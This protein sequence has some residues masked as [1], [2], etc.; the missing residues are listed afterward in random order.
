M[1]KYSNII[2]MITAGLLITGCGGSSNSSSVIINTDQPGFLLSKVVNSPEFNP[3]GNIT[4]TN[5]IFSWPATKNATQYQ[6]GHEDPNDINSWVSHDILASEANCNATGSRYCKFQ[7][8]NNNFP[9]GSFRA[10][11]VRAKVNGI[12]KNWSSSHTFT[13]VKD[14]VSV[15][16]P[17]TIAPTGSVN[18]TNPK[19][20]WTGVVNA[21]EYRLGYEEQTTENSWVEHTLSATDLGCQNLAQK[22]VFTPAINTFKN[23]DH[24]GWYVR[25]YSAGN[26]GEW[27][28]VKTFDVGIT[29][30]TA[31][32]RINEV[33]AANTHTNMDPDF[34]EFSDWIEIYNPSNQDLNISNYG[35]SD[36][37]QPL[38]WKFPNGTIIKAKDYLIVWAD[39]KNMSAKALHTNFKLSSKGEKITLANSTGLVIDTIDFKK[40]NSDVSAANKNG[41]IVFMSPTPGAQNSVSHDSKK[42]S[43]V[44]DYSHASGFYDNAISVVLSQSNNADIYYTLDGSIPS[45]TSTKY[46]QPINIVKTSVIRAAAL[47]NGGLFSEIVS[48]T[49]FVNHVTT[50]PVVSMAVDPA[51]LFDPKTGIYTDGDGTNGAPLDDCEYNT[52]GPKN[53]TQ[54]WERPADIEYFAANQASEF[55]L[56]AGLSIAG[57]CSRGHEKKPFSVE[58]DSKYGTKTLDYKLYA[59][60]TINKFKDF[61]FR[62]GQNGYQISDALAAALVKNGNLNIDYQAYTATQMF[63]NGNYWGLYNIREKKGADFLIS[64]YPNLKKKNLDIINVGDYAKVGDMNDYDALVELLYLKNYDLSANADYQE[65]LTFFDEDSY[66]DYMAL[67]IYSANYDWINSNLRCW[68]EK[69]PAKKWRWMV[70]DVDAG[71]DNDYIQLNQ[72]SEIM[73]A[74]STAVMIDLF[75]S[76]VKNTT[77]KQKFK[78]RLIE[79]L[80]T[81][82]STANMISVIDTI[83]NE[84]KDYISL[85]T[86]VWSSITVDE[87]DYYVTTLKD[88][89]NQRNAVVR[90]QLDVFIP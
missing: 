34:I 3:S 11:W 53:Y 40:Q 43:E 75:R 55:D 49:Y 82:F 37:D 67:M 83:I 5:P 9:I 8:T 6:V 46:T 69:K 56:T 47:E 81:T 51:H 15:G 27:S 59:D 38:N 64:N 18:T 88:F 66:I 24:I 32:I 10:W 61:K 85:E 4:E 25:A 19:F 31:N 86:P 35:L 77:F 63:V 68:K 73:N 13:V 76:L 45:L 30:P 44:P 74:D 50:L 12:W 72:F 1:A 26:L 80:D 17:Q 41:A 33:L 14:L 54:D 78:T 84:R 22:C 16:V 65:L 28:P 57:Q 7:P 21:T 29:T 20:T 62:P 42:K 58:L 2:L 23:G 48:K 70:D 89:A 87:F 52:V 60:K 90:S 79:L 71:F 36:D 39:K